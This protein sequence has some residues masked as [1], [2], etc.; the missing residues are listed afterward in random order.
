MTSVFAQFLVSLLFLIISARLLLK[1]IE[2]FASKIRI[3]PLI[4]GATLIA[5]GTSLPETSVAISAIAQHVP[6]IS[7]G[8]IVGSNIANICLVLGFGILVFPIR[9]GT[10]KTQKNNIILLVLTLV[11][12]TLLSI[13]H[14]LSRFL[15]IGLVIFYL[16][17]LIVEIFWGRIGGL[18]ED[19]KTIAHLDKSKGNIFIY[20]LGI[21]A[22]LAGLVFSSKFLVSSVIVISK[23]L[24]INIL[25]LV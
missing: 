7:F 2:S 20:L 6:E 5:I 12:I 11:F 21:V 3:S 16:V 25:I 1:C 13:P 18:K 15:G 9:I 4:I 24:K 14:D 10:T 22:S 19:K 17:F 8:D 23:L